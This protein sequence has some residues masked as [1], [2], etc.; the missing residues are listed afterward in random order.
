VLLPPFPLIA[1]GMILGVMDGAE[2][3]GKFIAH[4]EGYASLLCV[5]DVMG[6]RRGAATDKARLASHIMFL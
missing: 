3:H 5:A 4:F 1:G 6:M 2:R